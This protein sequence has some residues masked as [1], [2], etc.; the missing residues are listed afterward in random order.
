MDQTLSSIAHRL[1]IL[2]ELAELR[3]SAPHDSLPTLPTFPP[4]AT[5]ISSLEQ[6]TKDVRAQIALEHATHARTQSILDDL[7]RQHELLLHMVANR[8]KHLPLVAR[9]SGAVDE[10]AGVEKE[11]RRGVEREAGDAA[12]MGADRKKVLGNSGA[13]NRGGVPAAGGKRAGE[14][15]GE[16]VA[17]PVKARVATTV[18]PVTVAEF[19]ALPKYLLVGRLNRDRI[20]ELFAEFNKVVF[21]KLAILRFPQAK[22]SKEQRDI[23]WEHRKAD[24][25]ETKG[26]TFITEKDI[27]DKERWSKSEF[28]LNPVGRSTIA[29]MRH[30]GRIKEVRGGGHT[31]IVIM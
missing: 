1:E 4:L 21:D 25:E 30:L 29:I 13:L 31:R 6:R 11:G 23:F 22:M 14:K 17:K 19:D 24:V 2:K 20:N 28:R 7:D 3:C 5:E 16:E 27:K 8:P 26:K 9:D 18:A 12:G 15:K 10:G